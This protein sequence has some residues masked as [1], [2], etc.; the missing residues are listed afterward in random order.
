VY[1]RSQNGTSDRISIGVMVAHHRKKKVKQSRR[2][3]C[4][5][6]HMDKNSHNRTADRMKEKRIS[7][8]I[9]DRAY[10]D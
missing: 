3:A 10:N 8:L 5:L 9:E 7:F 4:M 6:C 1:Q 2:G